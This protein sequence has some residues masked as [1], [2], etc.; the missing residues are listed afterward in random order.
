MTTTPTLFSNSFA[1]TPFRSGRSSE[2]NPTLIEFRKDPSRDTAQA[3][4][5]T[6]PDWPGQYRHAR[7]VI[8]KWLSIYNPN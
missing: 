4:L 7:M 1:S 5:A 6:L 8:L 3:F 2:T